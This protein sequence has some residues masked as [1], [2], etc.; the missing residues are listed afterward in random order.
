MTLRD[1]QNLKA[2]VTKKASSGHKDAENTLAF[3]SNALL[4]NPDDRGG[5]AVDENDEWYCTHCMTD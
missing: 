5:V 1:I 3:L 4:E 2:R